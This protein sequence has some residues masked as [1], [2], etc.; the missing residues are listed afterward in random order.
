M[1]NLTFAMLSLVLSV[2]ANS[3]HSPDKCLILASVLN[4]EQVKS[5]FELSFKNDTFILIDRMNWFKGLCPSFHVGTSSI[6]IVNDPVNRYRASHQDPYFAFKNE[7][8]TLLLEEYTSHGE[9]FYLTILRPCKNLAIEAVVKKHKKQLK[10]VSIK[11]YA[12]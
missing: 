10:V 8:Q 3:Q 2:S 7:C 4:Q 12:L 11:K 1:R 6:Q 9:L 5:Y